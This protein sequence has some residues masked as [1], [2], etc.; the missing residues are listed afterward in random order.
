[1]LQFSISFLAVYTYPSLSIQLAHCCVLLFI[2]FVLLLSP[3]LSDGTIATGFSS[4]L[5]PSYILSGKLKSANIVFL[6]GIFFVRFALFLILSS[7]ALL[8]LF[9][10]L[11]SIALTMICCVHMYLSRDF[12]FTHLVN[13]Y[14]EIQIFDSGDSIPRAHPSSSQ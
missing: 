5:F 3:S 7:V 1:M 10:L 2:T 12:N 8:S 11:S 9:L 4:T 13:S 6:V 14:F